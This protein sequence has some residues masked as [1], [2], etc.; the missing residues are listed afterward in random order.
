MVNIVE[1]WQDRI[2]SI[3]GTALLVRQTTCFMPTAE[4][5]VNNPTA[6]M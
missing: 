1:I 2:Q 5:Y 3:V 6:K 4:N